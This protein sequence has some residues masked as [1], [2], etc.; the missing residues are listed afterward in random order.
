MGV[1]LYTA[2]GGTARIERSGRHYPGLSP[3]G[4]FK[5]KRIYFII[6][7]WMDNHW[8][9]L[10]ERAMGQPELASDPRF[11]DNA[12]RLSNRDQV[13]EVIERWLA[14]MPDDEKSLE[15]M[16]AARIPVAPIRP[17]EEAM[18]NPHLRQRGTVAKVHDR[19]LGDF[20]IPAFPIRFS[21][22]PVDTS[23]EAPML[24]EHNEE[25]LKKHLAYS[26]D[27]IASLT[28]A[29]ILQSKPY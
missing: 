23:Q 8:A 1:E 18:N 24:G 14:S 27:R 25:I 20:E 3:C 6:M 11:I 12:K 10:C 21:E 7:A 29:G 13:V 22:F 4:I 9:Q 19:I 5:G 2:S 15:V 16:R 28:A 17:L 26:A